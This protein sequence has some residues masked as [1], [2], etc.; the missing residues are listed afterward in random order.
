MGVFL[1]DEIIVYNVLDFNIR[2]RNVSV[3][4]AR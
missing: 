3:V 1:L 2:I 4:L